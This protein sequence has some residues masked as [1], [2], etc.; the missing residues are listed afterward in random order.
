MAGIKLTRMISLDLFSIVIFPNEGSFEHSLN[1][2]S[3]DATQWFERLP[4][5]DVYAKVNAAKTNKYDSINFA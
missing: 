2:F 4:R 5:T 3:N 1:I